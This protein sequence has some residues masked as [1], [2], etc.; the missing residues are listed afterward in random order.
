MKQEIQQ[1]KEKGITLIALVI[2][3]IVLL[4]LAGVTIATLTGDN[5][6]LTKTNEAKE[7][8]EIETE[9]EIIKLAVLAASEKEG[10]KDI[11][12]EKLQNELEQLSGGETEVYSDNKSYIIYFKETDR[13]YKVDENININQEE[14]EIVE[15][16]KNKYNVIDLGSTFTNFS[17]TAG[18]VENMD[19]V[20]CNDTSLAH[21]A[22]AMKK[23][24]WILLPY[25]YNWRW[26]MDLNHCDWYDSVKLY[27]Q[28]DHGDWKSVFSDVERDLKQL[29]TSKTI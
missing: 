26:H 7:S 2:T 17:D 4:I 14:K 27:R 11:S 18:A 19:L 16:I 22:G 9:K 24:C 8:T 1:K 23:P 6:I 21:L 13:V 29:L 25:I 28:P 15:K 5:G 3:I 10:Y 20:I 12:K